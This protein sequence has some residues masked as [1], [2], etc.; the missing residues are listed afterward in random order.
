MTNRLI[1]FVLFLS[2]LVPITARGDSEFKPITA[3]NVENLTEIA[4]LGRGWVRNIK[5]SPNDNRLA[6]LT[7][8]GIYIH[9]NEDFARPIHIRKLENAHWDSGQR[10][11]EPDDYALNYPDD[12]VVSPDNTRQVEDT[13]AGLIIIYSSDDGERIAE[14][15]IGTGARRLLFSNDSERIIVETWTRDWGTTIFDW[16]IRIDQVNVLPYEEY[17]SPYLS[18]IAISADDDWLAVAD[19][20]N[21]IRIFDLT[22]MMLVHDLR[23]SGVAHAI[24]FSPD[25]A[26]LVSGSETFVD[27][28]ELGW[29]NSI[30]VWNTTTL[31]LE[32]ELNGHQS[33]VRGL[34]F[35][36]DGR[37]LLS[38]ADWYD[39]SLLWEFEDRE[40]V[41]I[42]QTTEI[43]F[44]DGF[45]IPGQKQ[46]GLH[47][48]GTEIIQVWTPDEIEFSNSCCVPT[49]LVARS[50][51][52]SNDN[53]T[54][55]ATEWE[56][57]LYVNAGLSSVEW[58]EKPI[59]DSSTA[60]TL[61]RVESSWGTSVAFNPS[62]TFLAVGRILDRRG[63]VEVWS[64][65]NLELQLSVTVHEESTVFGNNRVWVAYSPNGEILLAGG[66]DQLVMIDTKN[67]EVITSVTVSEGAEIT[68]LAF[69]PDGRF[70]ATGTAD[71]TIRLWG[72]PA[73]D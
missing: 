38:V 41:A 55:A 6:V 10:I 69:S 2:V 51:S 48:E 73:S 57:R 46:I 43:P 5:W 59:F 18:H 45:F 34:D 16:N 60:E 30:F 4:Q 25:S 11:F 33:R 7:A 32:D 13:G 23:Y 50:A 66:S 14:K 36:S 52:V 37:Y 61:P 8:T 29:D 70:I 56:T 67:N 40:I 28:T 42:Q 21:H 68:S 35:S 19:R 31:A 44:I 53:N 39:T 71:G 17:G 64:L 9:G 65:E 54:V 49:G 58:T 27:M 20:D 15:R 63:F 72:V 26:K 24:S 62:D 22:S 3:D 1:L 12:V 47:I